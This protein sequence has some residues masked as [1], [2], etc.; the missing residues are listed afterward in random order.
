MRSPFPTILYDDYR[1]WLRYFLDFRAKYPLPDDRS[2]Q[3][4]FFIE[5]I[6]SKGQSGKSLHYA[7][8]ALSLFF[9]FQAKSKNAAIRAEP[10][11][12]ELSSAAAASAADKNELAGSPASAETTVKKTTPLMVPL[13]AQ[14]NAVRKA[15]ITKRITSHT[16]RHSF[17]THLLQANYDIRTIQTLLG[18]SDVRTTMIYTHCIPS[19]TVKEAKSP[20][21]F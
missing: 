10:E 19:R 8:H 16:F 9:S 11:R 6:R 4:R 17:A 14:Y 1:K 7:S 2:E 5:K 20:L 21:D 15:R 13:P 12:R 3:V 18:H